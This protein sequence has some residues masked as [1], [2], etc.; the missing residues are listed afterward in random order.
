V[1]PQLAGSIAVI[2]SYLHRRVGFLNP[3]IYHFAAGRN[4]PFTPLMSSGT[5][6]DNMFYT[7]RKGLRY[8]PG[9]GLGTPNFARL[10][11]CVIAGD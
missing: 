7:G 1:A 2:D 11:A 5:S 6:N 9:S 8:N 4:S 10:C 3:F